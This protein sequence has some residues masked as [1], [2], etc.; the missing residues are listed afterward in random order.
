[1]LFLIVLMVATGVVAALARRQTFVVH[2]R[3]GLA[4]AMAV[5][6]VT[7]FLMPTPF[8]QHLPQWVPERHALIYATGIVEMALAAGLI[9]PA[10][11]R[12][13]AGLA[14]AAYLMSVFPANVYVAVEAVD[15]DGQPG[16]VYPWLRLPLQAV[17]VWLALW[18]TG[19]PA[20]LRD[21]PASRKTASTAHAAV[22]DG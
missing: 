5:A 22:L 8:V 1:M 20:F 11:W 18:S 2:V 4:A 21:L 3:L 14:L 16:G 13:L 9:W 15:V 6:G 7:H 19:A 17:F 12:A 10:Q